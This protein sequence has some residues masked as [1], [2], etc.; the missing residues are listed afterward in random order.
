[1]TTCTPI[2]RGRVAAP[3]LAA[4]LALPSPALGQ[5][6]PDDT[7]LAQ[8]EVPGEDQEAL[9]PPAFAI[10]LSG[11][12]GG[13]L[14]AYRRNVVELE[15]T[16]IPNPTTSAGNLQ[17]AYLVDES[18]S[19]SLA[20]DLT[21]IIDALSVS[22]SLKTLGRERV[23]RVMQGSD[24]TLLAIERQRPDG[25]VDDR[26]VRYAPLDPPQSVPVGQALSS[27]IVLRLE[28]LYRVPVAASGRLSVVAP[29]GGGA[30][31][32][33]IPEPTLPFRLGVSVRAGLDVSYRVSSFF[34]IGA[35]ANMGA[36]ATFSYDDRE[37]V[38]RR[39]TIRGR[40]SASAL[41]STLV[42]AAAHLNLTFI[43]R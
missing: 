31:L 35:N 15:D 25:T 8:G 4:L 34:A 20:F 21:V 2:R 10:Q 33:H 1:M 41:F 11:G 36:L 22:T 16:G 24:D 13:G 26:G 6:A 29:V 18:A 43:V 9:E 28:G 38:A 27:L 3:M 19:S 39:A 7:S 23:T 5:Q 14:G 40:S 17:R 37:D 42:D 32:V 12:V 30:A